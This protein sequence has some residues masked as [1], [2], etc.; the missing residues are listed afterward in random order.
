MNDPTLIDFV[1]F[2]GGLLVYT[3]IGGVAFAVA[4]HRGWNNGYKPPAE[5][6]GVF[7]PFI[8]P[9]FA[10][11]WLLKTSIRFGRW[12][13][14]KFTEPSIPTARVVTRFKED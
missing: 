2:C 6:A 4:E 3:A 13:V 11:A 8:L 12:T 9:F 5:L 1:I 10:I 14:R 7:W